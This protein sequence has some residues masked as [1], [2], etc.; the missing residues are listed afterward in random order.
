MLNWVE[1]WEEKNVSDGITGGRGPRLGEEPTKG[2]WPEGTMRRILAGAGG[3]G[4]RSQWG[5]RKARR[6]VLH[7][8]VAHLGSDKYIPG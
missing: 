1:R 5:P 7:S 2:A 4:S 3:G 6:I 8:K